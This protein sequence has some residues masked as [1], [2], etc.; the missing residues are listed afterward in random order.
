MKNLSGFL[1]FDGTRGCSP[2]FSDVCLAQLCLKET[3]F[4]E[5]HICPFTSIVGL[6]GSNKL[7]S[8]INFFRRKGA[9]PHSSNENKILHFTEIL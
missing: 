9:L 5:N 6:K 7:C 1:R 4:K 8:K 2:C 3:G